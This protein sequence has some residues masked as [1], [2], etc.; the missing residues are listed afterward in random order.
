M[1]AATR[2]EG[3]RPE[4]NQLTAGLTDVTIA[5]ISWYDH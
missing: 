2:P 4:K 3:K 5:V 1:P